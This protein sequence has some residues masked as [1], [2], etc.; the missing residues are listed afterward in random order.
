MSEATPGGPGVDP[1]LLRAF[2]TV[3]EERHFGRAAARLLLAQP[4]LSRQ[5]QQLERQLRVQLFTRTP[6]G[7]ELTEVG[8]LLLPEAQRV[9]AAGQRLL[10]AARAHAERPGPAL[11]VA[12]PLPSPT[13]GLLQGAVRLF[14][15]RRPDG[16]I[17]VV[18]V[19][20][21]DQDAALAEGR[22][23]VALT[24]ERPRRGGLDGVTL[25]REQTSALLAAEHRRAGDSFF[26]VEQFAGEALLFP[27]AERSHC[28]AQ[29]RDL[30]KEAGADLQSVPTAPSAVADLVAA[31]LG[32]SAVPGSF[33]EWRRT[34][35][36]LLPVPG[37]VGEMSAVW[38]SG[39]RTGAVASFVDACLQ[40]ARALAVAQPD[41][42]TVD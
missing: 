15:A 35:L 9:L 13:G 6:T 38:R 22:I 40:A 34:D 21:R 32:V 39:E 41:L 28:W 14:R 19:D 37:L 27:V 24:W 3:A 29:L 23:D 33:R 20:D 31:G 36:A 17:A 5:V 42:W 4:A 2:L 1:R 11:T 8:T 26:P 18:E 16:A 12:A 7:A 30:A 10:R 25:G